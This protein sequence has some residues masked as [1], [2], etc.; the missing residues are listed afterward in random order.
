MPELQIGNKVRYTGFFPKVSDIG[1]IVDIDTKWSPIY[2]VDF[3][4]GNIRLI[5]ASWLEKIE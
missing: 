3:G 1:T 4:N 5:T 2:K